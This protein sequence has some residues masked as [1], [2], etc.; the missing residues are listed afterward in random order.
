[1]AALNIVGR[2]SAA[3]ALVAA[4]LKTAYNL[5]APAAQRVRVKGWSVAFDGASTTAVPVIVK[6]GM[7]TQATAGTT[8]ASNPLKTDADVGTAVASTGGEN[9]S[10][11]PT[12][13]TYLDIKEVHPQTG[14]A[15]WY[16]MGAEPIIDAA[17]GF[18]IECTAPAAVNV[19]ATVY[20]EE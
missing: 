11:E 2:T 4:T 9:Y 15:Q 18:F 8:T 10:A 19:M 13:K 1:M 14:F 5:I 12:V 7:S 3:V 16:P 20:A 6:A 17:A